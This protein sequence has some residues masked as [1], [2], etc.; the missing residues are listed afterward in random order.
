MYHLNNAKYQSAII[1]GRQLI[2]T[3]SKIYKEF[4]DVYEE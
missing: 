1:F 4:E 3:S 2:F